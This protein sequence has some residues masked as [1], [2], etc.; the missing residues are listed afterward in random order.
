MELISSVSKN[1]SSGVS[2]YVH[3]S[4]CSET[5]AT[6]ASNYN[7]PKLMIDILNNRELT[8]LKIDIK[9]GILYF[10]ISAQQTWT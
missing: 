8:S 10:L 6:V 4:S 2:Y 9:C 1:C 5:V 3:S 7:Y